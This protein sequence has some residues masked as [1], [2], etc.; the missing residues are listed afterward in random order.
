MLINLTFIYQCAIIQ[1]TF[2]AGAVSDHPVHG[3]PRRGDTDRRG[4]EKP[5]TDYRQLGGAGCDGNMELAGLQGS[6]A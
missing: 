5:P 4:K 3:G 2:L 1:N 6:Q